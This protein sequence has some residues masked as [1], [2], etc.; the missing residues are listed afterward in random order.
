MEECG[1]GWGESW[2][3]GVHACFGE[4]GEDVGTVIKCD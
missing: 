3:D 4:E 1:E 2:W